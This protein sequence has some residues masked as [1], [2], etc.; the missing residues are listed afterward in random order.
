MKN[1]GNK[2]SGVGGT[3]RER[4]DQ[5]VCVGQSVRRTGQGRAG[6]IQHIKRGGGEKKKSPKPSA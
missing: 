2:W 4:V 5:G 3:F 1:L 6:E